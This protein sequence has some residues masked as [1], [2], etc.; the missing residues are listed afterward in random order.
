[1]LIISS[2]NA[3]IVKINCMNCHE[4]LIK[5]KVVHPIAEDA[6]DNCHVYS[7]HSHPGSKGNEFTLVETVPNLCYICHEAQNTKTNIHP[8]ITDG[9]CWMCHSPHASPNPGLLTE[10]PV[11]RTC[12]RCHNLEIPVKDKIHAPVKNGKCNSCHNPHQSDLSFL[13]K[14]DKSELCFKCHGSVEEQASYEVIHYPFDDDCSN[15]HTA[16]SSPENYL[17]TGKTPDLC[18]N[19]HD[20]YQEEE[21]VSSHSVVFDEK[22]CANCHSP[23][24]SKIGKLLIAEGTNLC[25]NCHNKKI[26]TETHSIDNIS[27]KIKSG[28]SVHAAIEFEGCATCHLPHTS[29]FAYLLKANYP[30]RKYAPADAESFALCFECHD[31]E[32]LVQEFTTDITS[33][34]DDNIN[35]HYLH[36]KGRKGRS[37]GL[38][39]DMHASTNEHLINEKSNF[40]SWEM[41]MNYKVTSTGG[42]CFP[43]CHAEESYTRKD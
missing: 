43:G 28:K 2:A 24:A 37:C 4:K 12:D 13:L 16:H 38:C 8:P 22:N 32:I 9:Y 25:M 11:K 18:F 1:M 7:N 31:S 41:D 35:L 33:F 34:R 27:L 40:G 42:S 10:S 20:W 21:P 5:D 23:H 15:C 39:H 6:C 26:K 3:Q 36:I 29:E 19:C 17:L 30:L 14:E